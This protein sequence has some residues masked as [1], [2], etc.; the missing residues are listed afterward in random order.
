MHSKQCL[1]QVKKGRKQL[2]MCEKLH[3]KAI[4]MKN[5]AMAV[6]R[7]AQDYWYKGQRNLSKCG[8]PVKTRYPEW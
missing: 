7:R 4:K 2:Q 6:E 5:K 8:F 3:K 1:K